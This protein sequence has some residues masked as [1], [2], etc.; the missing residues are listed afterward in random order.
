MRALCLLAP[1]MIACVP[2]V[3]YNE[4]TGC[5]RAQF[6]RRYMSLG[7]HGTA[8]SNLTARELPEAVQP[9]PMAFSYAMSAYRQ[10]LTM[11]A[12][13]IVGA[14]ALV[15]GLV[16]GFAVD[17]TRTDVRDAGYGIVGGALGLGVVS[18]LLNYTSSRDRTA[19]IRTLVKYA[20]TCAN[21]EPIPEP[22][23]ALPATQ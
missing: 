3:E 9:H 6:S 4:R 7:P 11:T 15:S 21:T 23:E 19:A 5:E 16:M 14:A 8:S 18:L 1:L 20:D 12:L 10:S 22:P 17:P 13:S 2:V